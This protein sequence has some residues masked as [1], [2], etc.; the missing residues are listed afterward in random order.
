MQLSKHKI[1]A[2]FIKTFEEPVYNVNINLN[3]VD[4]KTFIIEEKRDD[5]KVV[6]E[7]FKDLVSGVDFFV[8]D[9][10]LKIDVKSRENSGLSS[11][12]KLYSVFTSENKLNIY[13][14]I[15]F[16]KYLIETIDSN[17]RI[18][19]LHADDLTVKAT[20]GT[21]KVKYCH[22]QENIAIDTTSAN[23]S[24]KSIESA[25]INVN[26]EKGINKIRNCN[27]E[28][29]NVNSQTGVVHLKDIN[30]NSTIDVI[31]ESGSID[32]DDVYAS[33]VNIKATTG[34]VNYFNGH[35]NKDF[36]VNIDV[37]EAIVRTNV[38]REEIH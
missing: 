26:N 32:L 4:I 23:V 29:L 21:V 5:V 16:K 34:I 31:S 15:E 7:G 22:L 25:S 3:E 12:V 2:E 33:V 20:S 8:E 28:N 27:I 6:F 35:F 9:G 19:N 36:T 38:N 18:N 1:V 13:M 37:K 17:L 11:S 14:P 10:V 24:V 30:A